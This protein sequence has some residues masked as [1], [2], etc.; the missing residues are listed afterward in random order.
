M[1]ESRRMPI[2]LQFLEYSPTAL[3]SLFSRIQSQPWAMVLQSAADKH[4]DNRFDILVAD[5]IATLCSENGVNTIDYR[6]G[7]K[8][9][10]E[11]DPFEELRSLQ[12][13]LLPELAPMQPWPF[14]GGAMGYF[15][16]DLG[17]QVESLPEL[18]LKDVAIPDMGVGLY[19]WAVIAD[20]TEKKLVIIQP[21]G[22]DR[23]TWIMTN[24]IADTSPFSLQGD[25][26]ANMTQQTYTEKFNR[27][28]AYLKSG[29]C[30][31]INLA[32]RF[33][34]A[35][36]AVNGKPTKNSQ[37]PTVRRSRVLFA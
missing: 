4:P 1:T 6:D 36:Q 8:A 5:P 11:S 37:A 24:A 16:Y 18:A 32:Q 3:T 31:Q 12:R 17:R 22:H 26:Q 29:D 2:T 15:S 9:V 30:Y 19:D 35:Y 13:A 20:H 21:K 23:F 28:Q 14:V 10:T 34:A 7:R 33:K 25:W 27:V